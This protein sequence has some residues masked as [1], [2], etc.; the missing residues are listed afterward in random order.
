MTSGVDVYMYAL[1][2]I[3]KYI[4]SDATHEI[5]IPG[6]VKNNIIEKGYNKKI[7]IK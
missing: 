7:I 1:Y 2:I 3:N 5:N 6:R 4:K